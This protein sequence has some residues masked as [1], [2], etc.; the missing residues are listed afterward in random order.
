MTTFYCLRFETPLTCSLGPLVYIL[1]EQGGPVIP[2]A[3]GSIS[4]AIYDS[5]GYGGGN[6]N[7]HPHSRGPVC[8]ALTQKFKADQIQ[9][10][11][12]QTFEDVICVRH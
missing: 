1:Q 12:Q 4:I 6:S 9:N 10:I 11:E 5:Q 7:P 2:P 3:L 8:Y